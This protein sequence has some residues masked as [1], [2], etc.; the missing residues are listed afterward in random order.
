M[1]TTRLAPAPR[2]APAPTAGTITIEPASTP[3]W[4]NRDFLLLWSGGVVSAIGSQVSQLAFP[5]LILSVTGSPLQAGVMSALRGLP[6]ALFALPAGALVDRWDRRRVMILCDA[7]RA[8]ALGSIP[9]AWALGWLSLPQLY[10]VSLIEGTLAIFF[11]LA[12]TAAIARVVPKPQLGT[13][14]AQNQTAGATAEL[15]GPAAGGALYSLGAFVPF[16]VD[17]LS[18]AASAAALLLLRTR[19][20]VERAAAPLRLRAEIAE[21]L[22]WVWRQQPVRYL[23]LITWGLNTF[24]AGYALIMIVIAEGQGASP[25]TI[26]LVLGGGGIGGIV[27]AAIAGRL[28]ARFRLGQILVG[29][30]WFW[31]L[32]W[33]AYAAAP[34]VV[35]LAVINAVGWLCVPA[36]MVAQIGYRVAITPDALQGRVNSV[37]RLIAYGSAPLGLA[38]TGWLLEA[39]GPIATVLSLCVPQVLCAIAVT[40]YA[41]LRRLPRLDALGGPAAGEP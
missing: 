14:L 31:A 16:L 3:L 2:T 25:W 9:L 36:Y 38:L 13:A 1:T 8:L 12:E 10:A 30:A 17:A 29:S 37:Y 23:A 34:N 41:P 19:L 28:L 7:L 33:A 15:L 6:Y 22:G 4:R 5:L 18:Y 32:S 21:G 39:V 11:G 24:C 26:G 35:W 27:G 20:H 40:L